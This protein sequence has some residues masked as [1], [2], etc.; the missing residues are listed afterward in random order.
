MAPVA[1]T[2][3]ADTVALARYLEDSL[4]RAADAT[5]SRAEAGKA[6]M[7]VPEIVIAEFVY[8][9]LKGRLE[10]PEP[11]STVMEV[12]GDVA[13]SRHLKQVGVPAGAWPAFVESKI[14]ELHDRIIHATASFYKAEAII[15]NDREL[16]ASGYPTIW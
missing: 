4:P 12:L 9:A 13:A 3:I 14:S 1:D 6:T 5:F 2:Y 15:T 10:V 11:R 8:I 16:V 7:L